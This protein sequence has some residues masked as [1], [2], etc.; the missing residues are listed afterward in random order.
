MAELINKISV[1]ARKYLQMNANGPAVWFVAPA[2]RRK[3][4]L[5]FHL[6]GQE[7]SCHDKVF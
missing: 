1:K 2:S 7:L 3:W 5:L 6:D 4:F